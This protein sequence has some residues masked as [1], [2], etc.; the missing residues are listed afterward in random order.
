MLREV[1]VYGVQVYEGTVFVPAEG[2]VGC[3]LY[4]TPIV[5]FTNKITPL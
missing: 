4:Y 3:Q 1:R 2:N 5:T